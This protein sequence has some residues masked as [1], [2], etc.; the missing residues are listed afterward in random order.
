M[1]P[2]GE[3]D[4]TSVRTQ[5]CKGRGEDRAPIG[6]IHA[7]QAQAGDHR[8]DFT[9]RGKLRRERVEM[10]GIALHKAQQRKTHAQVVMQRRVEFDRQQAVGLQSARKQGFGHHAVPGPVRSRDVS[11]RAV[12]RP[13]APPVPGWMGDGRDL[14]RIA[15][16]APE[17]IPTQGMAAMSDGIDMHAPSLT[18]KMLA[19]R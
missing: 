18:G 11:Q 4:E 2:V 1:R 17:E 3:L 16:P 13:F 10:A 6:F 8:V 5:Q 14:S 12:H 19:S 7:E 9:R 15:H